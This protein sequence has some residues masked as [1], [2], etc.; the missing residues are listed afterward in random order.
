[1]KMSIKMIYGF[2]QFYLVDIKHNHDNDYCIKILCIYFFLLKAKILNSINI[3][4]TDPFKHLVLNENM[5][6]PIALV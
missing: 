2:N 1:M 3:F 4:I 5:A 6:A